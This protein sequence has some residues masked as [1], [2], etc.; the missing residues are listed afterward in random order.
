MPKSN[1]NASGYSS[2]HATRRRDA[3]A[4]RNGRITPKSLED[5]VV[6]LASA[7]KLAGAG[8][9]AIRDQQRAGIPVTYKIGSKIVTRF[10]DGRKV[11]LGTVEPIPYTIPKGVK[12]IRGA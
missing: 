6:S 8:R 5:V 7:G 9:S 12:R 10:S 1:A 11:I 2:N 4:A 3:G